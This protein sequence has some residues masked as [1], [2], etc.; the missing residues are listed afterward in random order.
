MNLRDLLVREALLAEL[1]EP[2]LVRLSA[3]DGADITDI[4]AQDR[5]QG[6]QVELGVMREDDDV[7]R[8]V[9]RDLGQPLIRPAYA[10]FVRL[11]VALAGR[12]FGPVICGRGA[13]AE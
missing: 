4:L 6:G 3:A 2:V 10:R 13:L 11:R 9:E 1:V 8:A 12:E 7:G 5:A